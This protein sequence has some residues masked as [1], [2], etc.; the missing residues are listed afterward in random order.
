MRKIL[1]LEDNQYDLG[2]ILNQLKKDKLVFSYKSTDNKDD[3]VCLLKS[4]QPDI[5]LAD[6]KLPGFS[7]LEALEIFRQGDDN[8]PVIF[9]SGTIGEE[10][11]VEAMKNGLNDYILKDNLSRLSATIER[12]IRDAEIHR[13][14]KEAQE[15]LRI[16]VS[17]LKKTQA[18]AHL[19]SCEI[20][21]KSGSCECSHEFYKIFGLQHGKFKTTLKNIIQLIKPSERGILKNAIREITVTKENF[22][23]IINSNCPDK[24]LK[25]LHCV[26]ELSD[27]ERDK[28][29]KIILAVHDITELIEIKK[30]L[31]KVEKEKSMILDSTSELFLF[32][33]EN[34]KIKWANNAVSQYLNV[35]PYEF[36]NKYCYE[37]LFNHTEPCKKCPVLKALSTKQVQ[38][39]ILTTPDNK[40]WEVKGFPV[41]NNSGNIIG[42][43]EV[44]RDITKQKE[45]ENELIK[46]KENA[47]ESDRLKTA[48]LANMSHEIRTP[49]NSIIGF[50]EMMNKEDLSK[51]EKNYYSEIIKDSTNRLLYIINDIL[52][53][54]R[55][56]AQQLKIEKYTFNINELMKELYYEFE[57]YKNRNNKSDIEL[58]LQN[59]HTEDCYI[60]SDE[61]RLRQIL[62]NLLNNAFKFTDRGIIEFGYK[63]KDN[64]TIQFRVKDT[65]IGISREFQGIIFQRFRQVNES[66]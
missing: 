22:D 48:F 6:Y 31:Q 51:E 41:L 40:I 12:E 34:L 35:E 4:F 37:V 2:L 50:T 56:E 8:L 24:K 1:M 58:R 3:F 21:I 66:F 16:S 25:I 49:M 52:D 9:V 47:E 33:N 63:V 20:D 13:K 54:S 46:A 62:T 61:H 10:K 45:A 60:Y 15:L 39:N 5:V 44:A 17:N 65:G 18:I 59:K 19:G 53:L 7:G 36:E 57:L 30:A 29:D 64:Q 27:K 11:A 42:L 38:Y 14:H 55:I 28:N 26:G 23:I 43:G 32:Y